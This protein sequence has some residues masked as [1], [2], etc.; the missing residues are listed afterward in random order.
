M[1]G[2]VRGQ[3][4][5]A[6]RLLAPLSVRFIVVPIIDG[7]QS[8]RANPIKAPNGLIDSLSRQLDL[9]RLYASPDLVIFE[10]TSWV[11]IRSMLTAVGAESSKLAGAS[12]MIASDISGATPLPP[13]SRPEATVS[14][15]VEAGTL[16]LSIPYTT[17]WKVEL[18]GQQVVARPAFGLTD[19]FD[20]PAKGQVSLSFATSG[21]QTMAVLLQFMIW[22][23]V[24]FV[25]LSRR[26]RRVALRT[27][28]TMVDEGPVIVLV[29]GEP[30]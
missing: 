5:R 23:V 6:G 12:S 22:C 11:P 7:G 18:D 9:R 29:E 20:L 1:Y 3:T 8:T 13:A 17:K 10:N 28:A 14:A 19:A 16:H 30:S 4:S 21:L 26:R 2:I 24:A 15:V 27:S 25:A